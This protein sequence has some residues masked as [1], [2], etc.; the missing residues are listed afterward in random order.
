MGGEAK[1]TSGQSKAERMEGELM[2]RRAAASCRMW[3]ETCRRDYA[4]VGGSKTDASGN[5]VASLKKCNEDEARDGGRA[6]VTVYG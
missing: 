3:R 1:E 4:S 6:K 5:G 2:E